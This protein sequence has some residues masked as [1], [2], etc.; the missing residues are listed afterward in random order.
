MPRGLV[1]VRVTLI[2]LGTSCIPLQRV[3][4]ERSQSVKNQSEDTAGDMYTPYTTYCIASTFIYREIDTST[5]M[6]K[7]DRYR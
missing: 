5:A 4:D 3:D 7:G 2:S 1:V 6:Y